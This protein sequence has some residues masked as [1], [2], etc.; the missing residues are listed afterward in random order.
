LGGSHRPQMISHIAKRLMTLQSK[1]P[2]IRNRKSGSNW[3]RWRELIPALLRHWQR[4]AP[5]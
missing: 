4:G 5:P 1:K 2:G 3:L